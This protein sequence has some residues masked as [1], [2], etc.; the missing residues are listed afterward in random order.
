MHAS[1]KGSKM[2]HNIQISSTQLKLFQTLFHT[3]SSLTQPQKEELEA[4]TECFS[5][6]ILENSSETVHDLV[7]GSDFEFDE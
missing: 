4:L 6:I 3:P 7:F 5:D 2:I 1:T